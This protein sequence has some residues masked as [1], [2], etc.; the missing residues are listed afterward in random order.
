MI[1]AGY[2]DGNDACKLRHGPGFDFA[3][4]KGPEGEAAHPRVE[5]GPMIADHGA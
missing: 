1:G 3:L 5:V 2:E 4:K